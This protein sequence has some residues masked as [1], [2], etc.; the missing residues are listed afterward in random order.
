LEAGGED[1]HDNGEKRCRRRVE[2][3]GGKDSQKRKLKGLKTPRPKE[4]T[5]RQQRPHR[6]EGRRSGEKTAKQI[7]IKILEFGSKGGKKAC[8]KTITKKDLVR[9]R[10][11]KKGGVFGLAGGKRF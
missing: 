9:R 8:G 5:S 4:S 2:E 3:K 7:N 10:K 11:K 1:D 6:S